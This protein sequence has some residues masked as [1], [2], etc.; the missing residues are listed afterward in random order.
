MS[1]NIRD[2]IRGS[3]F[4][5]AAGDALGYAVEFMQED[6][7]RSAYGPDGITAYDPGNGKAEISDDTQ[8]TLFTANGLL[9]G[10]TRK[11]LQGSADA[12]RVYAA[13]ACLDWLTTQDRGS[14]DAVRREHFAS[15][16]GISWLLDVPELYHRR[17]PGT[18]CLSAL[19][20]LKEPGR[21][22][23]A[24]RANHSKGCGGIM[25]TAP[26][27]LAYRPGENCAM[28]Q[29]QLDLEGAAAAAVTHGH[30]LGFMPSAV[31]THIISRLLAGE[32]D[33][34]AAV[35]E[36]RDAAAQ[37]FAGDCHLTELTGII[38]L[39]VRLSENG[40]PDLENIH[41]LGEGW[42]AEETLG[43][44][45][46]CALK[47]KNDFSRALIVSVNHKGDSDSTGAVTG[48]I[49]GTLTGYDAIEDKWKHGLE[50][51]GV[52]LEIA[53]DLWHGC[54]ADTERIAADP[55]WETKY[56]RAHRY[57]EP[58]VPQTEIRMLY[59]DITALTDAEAIVNAANRSLLGGGGVD[60]AIH[61]A[62]GPGL[63]AECR[64]LRGCETG[65][66]KITGA[67]RL[68]C[69]YVIHTVGPVW[70]GGAEGE[71]ALLASC[72]RNSLQTA[73]DHGI[74]SIAF[75]SVSTGVYGFPIDRA[76]RIAVDT[77]RAFIA[78][79]PGALDL[80][81]WALFSSGDLQSYQNA[82]ER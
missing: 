17:A 8:M 29:E 13:L 35:L 80:V 16:N 23:I 48:N 34:K 43:I 63:L 42:V 58:A 40:A 61:A 79:H 65:E 6:A 67:Y 27:A 38:D 18:T 52:V 76:A 60:G 12:P 22:F 72:Y 9:Y 11:R 53:D 32:T 77:V 37:L 75:P 57:A 28:T 31:E 69:K 59:A 19:H 73:M 14:P 70:N 7:I 46:Y 39:A 21:D 49:L 66:A 64:K 71:D 20:A 78:E 47:Y 50:L 30:S 1:K 36:A 54:P 4:G 3:L 74:R 51:A 62:A 81:E 55:A 24:E 2:R 33:L 26:V 10:Q 15:G 45:L 44:A 5:G 56:V 25:R 82:A 68:P 41:A